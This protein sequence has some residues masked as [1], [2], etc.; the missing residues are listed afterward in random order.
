MKPSGDIQA[1]N[2]KIQDIQRKYPGKGVKDTT[3]TPPPPERN[4]A[5]RKRM[6]SLFDEYMEMERKKGTLTDKRWNSIC[7]QLSI[8]LGWDFSDRKITE[9][10]KHR[11][12]AKIRA[13][14]VKEEVA[15]EKPQPHQLQRLYFS[16]FSP[17]A[18]EVM[19]ESKIR[20]KSCA[21]YSFLSLNCIITSGIAK[22][23]KYEILKKLK[24]SGK[25]APAYFKEL[26]NT[27]L[28]VDKSNHRS[29]K[30]ETRFYL[31]HTHQHAKDVA[32]EQVDRDIFGGGE[33]VL[34]TPEAVEIL[35]RETNQR[36]IRGTHWYVY[37]YLCLNTYRETGITMKALSKVRVM[38][39]LNLD[40]KR[41]TVYGV[42][43]TLEE[44]G[45]II[46]EKHKKD[47]YFLPHILRKFAELAVKNGDH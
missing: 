46:Q 19:I 2:E 13:D 1:F 31:P 5:D 47:V 20:P 29:R 10:T 41:Q 42:F 30:K 25:N 23:S 17:A 37:A 26:E 3:S 22:V 4:E 32:T 36:K 43:K 7:D 39:D 8:R 27:G 38:K 12:N 28:I 21:I 6:D 33:W 35:A 45:L 16:A 44:L 18:L 14:F 40:V 34:I 9:H 15:T 24:L 11:R